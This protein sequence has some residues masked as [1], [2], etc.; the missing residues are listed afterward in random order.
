MKKKMYVLPALLLLSA[1][2]YR[3]TPVQSLPQGSMGLLEANREHEADVD[4][5]SKDNDEQ[6]NER[7]LGKGSD[8][9]PMPSD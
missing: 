7:D 9:E 3:A 6:K 1:C 4:A 8:K 5:Q 2:G